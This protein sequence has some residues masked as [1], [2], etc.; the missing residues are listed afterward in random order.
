MRIRRKTFVRGSARADISFR[1]VRRTAHPTG[2]VCFRAATLVSATER[3]RRRVTDD[4]CLPTRGGFPIFRVI[5]NLNLVGAISITVEKG[6]VDAGRPDDDDDDVLGG[7][8]CSRAGLCL[9][10]DI[11]GFRCARARAIRTRASVCRSVKTENVCAIDGGSF[12]EARA[13][14]RGCGSAVRRRAQTPVLISP[15]RL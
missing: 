2:E 6:Y 10:D 12:E 14:R 13:P 8:S 3:S 1:A 4:S 7:Y 11:D 5:R 9:R 15:C